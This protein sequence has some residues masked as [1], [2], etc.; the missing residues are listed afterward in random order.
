MP[1]AEIRES[2]AELVKD[3]DAAASMAARW[4]VFKGTA[5]A[6]RA[7][8]LPSRRRRPQALAVGARERAAAASAGRNRRGP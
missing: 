2:Y 8:P 1:W 6:T 3:R 7:E 4:K 5:E